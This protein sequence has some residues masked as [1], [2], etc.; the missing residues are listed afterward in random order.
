[1]TDYELKKLCNRLNYTP[2]KS[3]G[4]NTPAEVFFEKMGR[5]TYL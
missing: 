4:W 5:Y 1:M 2:R 3:L